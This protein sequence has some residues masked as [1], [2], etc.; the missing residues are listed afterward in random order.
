MA[1]IGGAFTGLTL[2]PQNL[3]II[4]SQDADEDGIPDDALDPT[5]MD[6]NPAL[7]NIL[8]ASTSNGLYAFDLDGNSFDVF[9]TDGDGRADSP[10]VTITGAGNGSI[11]GLAFSPLD[12]NLWTSH[13]RTGDLMGDT[14]SMTAT[15]TAGM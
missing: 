1:N 9:D 15:T 12:F 3:D 5:K 2:A 8:V 4:D 11:T 6:G 14:A 13:P 7:T 10:S